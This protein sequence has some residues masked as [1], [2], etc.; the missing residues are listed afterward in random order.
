MRRF[1]V[2]LVL[3]LAIVRRPARAQSSSPITYRVT[4]PEPEHHWLQVELTVPDT[5][6]NAQGAR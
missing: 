5:V 2:G 1:F 4:F 3:L 6:P